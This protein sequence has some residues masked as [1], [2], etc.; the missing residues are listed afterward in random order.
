[1]TDETQVETP[2]EDAPGLPVETE[3]SPVTD[4]QPET[5]VKADEQP[6]DE[7]G[8]FLSAKAQKRIDALTRE[9]YEREREAEYW[10]N[11][12]LKNQPKPEPVKVVEPEKLPTL[13]QFGYDEAKFHAALAEHYTKQA[14]TVVERRLAEEAEK[15]AKE[16]RDRTLVERLNAKPDLAQKVYYERSFP[17]SA[18]MS[19][20]IKDS[21]MGVELLEWIDNNRDQARRIYNLPERLAALE[22]GRIEGRL[23]AAKEAAKSRAPVIT[24]APPPPPKVEETAVEVEKDP[25][26]MSADQWMKWREKQLRKRNK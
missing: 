26:E 15:R 6:R 20:V 5:E 1:M 18:A 23:E 21:E 19:E 10:R 2:I 14:E 7:D 25:E 16:A 22:L 3:S 12:A 17:V 9:K 4:T 24:K 8:K 11:E 13:E